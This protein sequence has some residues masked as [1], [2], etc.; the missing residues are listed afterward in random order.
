MFKRVLGS[1]WHRRVSRSRGG[2]DDSEATCEFFP[3]M[4]EEVSDSVGGEEERE[5]ERKGERKKGGR[6]SMRAIA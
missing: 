4:G 1:S 3:Q 6:A 2:V 5:K